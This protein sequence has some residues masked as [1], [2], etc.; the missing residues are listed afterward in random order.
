MLDSYGKQRKQWPWD[1]SALVPLIVRW[2][3]GLLQG[4]ISS[5]LFQYVD[6]MPTLLC[7]ME[8][9]SPQ[10]VEGTDLGPA[11]A[12]AKAGP[13]SAFLQSSPPSPSRSNASGE[14]FEQC[15]TPMTKR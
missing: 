6:F 9:E 4:E 12:G 2:P 15:A 3:D 13:K 5:V 14:P 7:W 1:D 10:T 11:I 8:V